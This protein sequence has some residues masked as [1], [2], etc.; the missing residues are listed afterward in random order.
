VYSLNRQLNSYVHF[1]NLCI[2]FNTSAVQVASLLKKPL[3]LKPFQKSLERKPQAVFGFEKLIPKPYRRDHK[4]F[5]KRLERKP[6]QCLDLRNLSPN[7]IGVITSLFKKGLS[8]NP[9]SV[10]I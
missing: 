10:W 7:P 8:E 6:K 4:P 5:K 9:S 2:I 3:A 1:Y